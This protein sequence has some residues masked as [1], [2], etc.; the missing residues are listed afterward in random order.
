[1]VEDTTKLSPMAALFLLPKRSATLLPPLPAGASITTAPIT[2]LMLNHLPMVKKPLKT[3]TRAMPARVDPEPDLPRLMD[4][5]MGTSPTSLPLAM[6]RRA[7]MV[8][9][10]GMGAL[11]MGGRMSMSTIL[12]PD[13]GMAEDLRSMDL[14]MAGRASMR[15]LGPN[16]DLDM[17]G[18]TSM[19]VVGPNTDLVMAG[20]TSMG[21]L[22]PNMGLVMGGR[23]STGRNMA[24]GMARRVSMRILDLDTGGKVSIMNQPRST[25]LGMGGGLSRNMDLGMERRASV[26]MPAPNSP[27]DTGGKVGMMSRVRSMDLG[28]GGRLNR[29][30]GQVM[31]G[32]STSGPAMEGVRKERAM[33]ERRAMAARR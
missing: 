9:S 30:T 32:L 20:R 28:T 19:R 2:P 31:G 6:R 21:L 5:V 18:R 22:N 23:P 27:L 1:M 25:D 15:V 14:G 13:P 7:V 26:R 12:N 11:G 29:S 3:S 24:L 17:A 16:M 4:P 33:E 8:V 10:L